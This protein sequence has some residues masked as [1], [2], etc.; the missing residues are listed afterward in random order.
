MQTGAHTAPPRWAA[1]VRRVTVLTGAGISTD[2]GIPDFR[3]PEGAWTRNPGSEGKYTYELFL[4]DPAARRGFWES[5]RTH[6]AWSAEPNAGHVALAELSRSGID[7]TVITQNTDG[8]HQRAGL[9]QDRVIELHGTMHTVVCV[10]CGDHSPMPD[11]LVRLEAGEGDPHCLLCGGYLKTASVMSGQVIAPELFA[12]AEEAATGCD[13][14]LAVG[15]TLRVEPAASLCAIAVSSGAAL[16]VVNRD[17]TLYDGI[18]AEVVR[19]P[20]GEA[21]PRLAAQMIDGTR[22]GDRTEST[23]AGQDRAAAPRTASPTATPGQLLRPDARTARFRSRSAELERLEAWCTGSG[24]RVHLMTGPVGRG[25]T[26][27]ARELADRLV[28]V[29]GWSI[30]FPS[31]VTESPLGGAHPR[32]VVVDDAETEQEH[33]IRIVR[34]AAADPGTGPVRVLALARGAGEWWDRLLADGLKPVSDATSR[35]QLGPLEATPEGRENAFREAF[36]DYGSALTALGLQVATGDGAMEVPPDIAGLGSPGDLQTAAL[37]A[38]L[39]DEPGSAECRE[40]VL[41]RH[42]IDGWQ[43]MAE[44]HGLQMS[45]GTV[46]E[47]VA[48]AVLCGAEDRAA[49]LAVLAHIPATKS[50][51]EASQERAAQWLRDL[52]PPAPG[53]GPA[54]DAG[55]A[56]GEGPYWRFPLPSVTTERLV[57]SVVTTPGF[58]MGLHMETMEAQDARAFTVLARSAVS[59]PELV[60]TAAGLLT[61]LPGLSPAAVAAS[62][63]SAHPE[64]LADALTTLAGYA[65]LPAELLEGVPTDSQVLGEF[66]V[67]L[68]KSLIAAYEQRVAKRPE[69]VLPGL[70]RLLRELIQRLTSLGRHE[71]AIEA[72]RRAAAVEEQLAGLAP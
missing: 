7:L 37:V 22:E 3:G 9:S 71:E 46:R 21:L 72:S 47:A 28:A 63:R 57:A 62:Q 35:E 56:G 13:V 4:A 18:A 61:V 10:G 65:P 17:P 8:L 15:T 70:A 33:L 34:T 45:A 68:T 54:R 64:P 53:G 2:S 19:D 36:E 6:P 1:G 32:L 50:L 55:D 52:C 40:D 49:A 42:D 16:V 69:I 27:L 26:R 59:Q 24:V 14:L 23:R 5:R 58:L 60:D 12:R 25:K 66:A 48:A 29:G 11:T 44:E 51:D 20:I 31:G 30:E 43:R 41:L 67:L 38:A 39:G